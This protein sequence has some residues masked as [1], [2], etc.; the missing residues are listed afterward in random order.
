MIEVWLLQKVKSIDVV[1]NSCQQ[2]QGGHGSNHKSKSEI[3][4][5]LSLFNLFHGNS[6]DTVKASFWELFKTNFGNL[7]FLKIKLI[8]LQD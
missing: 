2:S 4:N 3:K 7:I 5:L 6:V 1:E 8:F